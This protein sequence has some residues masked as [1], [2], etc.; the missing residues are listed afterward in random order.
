MFENDTRED[1][2]KTFKLFDENGKGFITVD[3]LK[4]VIMELDEDLTDEE[5]L[6]MI[7]EADRDS[8]GEVNLDD[9]LRMLQ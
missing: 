9:F 8:D 7:D 1:M 4:K 2:I 3:D 6:E 5:I